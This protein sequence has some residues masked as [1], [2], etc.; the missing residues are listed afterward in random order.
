MSGTT[1]GASLAAKGALATVEEQ[2][3]GDT[4][5]GQDTSAA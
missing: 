3:A 4:K 1:V 2:D 5:R